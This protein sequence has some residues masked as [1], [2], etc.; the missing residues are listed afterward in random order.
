M[1]GHA[2]RPSVNARDV[3]A[4]QRVLYHPLLG[5]RRP[6]AA[7]AQRATRQLPPVAGLTTRAGHRPGELPAALPDA[8]EAVD[9]GVPES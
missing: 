6:P 5:H 9:S 3:G 8:V 1:T 7:D 4:A 2:H